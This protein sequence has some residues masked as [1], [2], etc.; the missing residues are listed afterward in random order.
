M[1]G[2]SLPLA[3]QFRA[4][5]R[6]LGIAAHRYRL[7][8]ASD[9]PTLDADRAIETL[10]SDG[11]VLILCFGNICRSPMAERYLR[12]QRD[13]KVG[14]LIFESAGFFEREG[15]PSPPEAIE[16][17]TAFDVDLSDHSSR[18]VSAE[19]VDRSDI[20]LLMD[21]R[22]LRRFRETFGQ[23]DE[24]YLLGAFGPSPDFEITDPYGADLD[25]FTAIYSEIV[26]ASD[27]IL[28]RLRE[29]H[30]SRQ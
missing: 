7:R 4:G 23:L 27:H 18:R 26:H 28:N 15:R 8:Y 6:R 17:A 16:A 14:S 11:H 19:M 21:V 10:G 2:E 3:A 1:S 20:V 25:H 24:T 29:S 9:P 5:K 30:A 22:N 12:D 13:G